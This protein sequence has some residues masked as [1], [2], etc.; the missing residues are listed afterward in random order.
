MAGNCLD[1]LDMNSSDLQ[2]WERSSNK[3][4]FIELIS[5]EMNGASVPLE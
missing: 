3:S 4:G 2:S 5:K 1:F